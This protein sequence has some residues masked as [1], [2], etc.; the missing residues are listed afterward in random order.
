MDKLLDSST[1]K[2][3]IKSQIQ[4]QKELDSIKRKLEKWYDAFEKDTLSADDLV[5]RIKDLREQRIYIE[6]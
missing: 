4:A 2:Y 6:K 3:I 5:E 1:N